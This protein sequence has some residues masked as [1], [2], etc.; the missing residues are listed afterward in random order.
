M[1]H[2]RPT[3]VLRLPIEVADVSLV[4]R[5]YYPLFISRTL[6]HAAV[7]LLV[8]GVAVFNR[9]NSASFPLSAPRGEVYAFPK[10]AFRSEYYLVKPAF[11]FT[12]FEGS[13]PDLPIAPK[14]D[15]GISSADTP[16]GAIVFYEVVEGD[17]VYTIAERFGLT[18]ETVIWAN[19][20]TDVDLLKIGQKL[21]ILPVNGVLH[22]VEEG[23]TVGSI[24]KRYNADPQAIVDYKAN[25]IKDPGQLKVG[26]KIIVPGGENPDRPQPLLSSRG[27]VR[28]L[29]QATG[30]FSW[31][32][33]GSITQYFSAYHA[34]I[35]IAAPMGTPVNAIDGGRVT[36]AERLS[37]GWG[38]YIV[39]D[40]GNGYS[41][42]YA[43]LSRFY[44]SVGERVGKGQPIGAVG[45]T[46]RTTG[47]HLH[48]E[49]RASGNLVNPLRVLP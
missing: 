26:D 15:T 33:W 35:D 40:H 7:F 2:L 6:L 41:S 8:I 32:T 19:D 31:P 11:A 17:A 14:Q 9:L 5:S 13:S 23:D 37:W 18:P 10:T 12:G 3:G 28:P 44:V 29:G 45:V 22:E 21:T 47:P 25:G 43:H 16:S 27:G 34:G 46:G 42:L 39:V 30:N 20:L 38:W 48:F 49:V 24:A 4:F 36:A 1:I